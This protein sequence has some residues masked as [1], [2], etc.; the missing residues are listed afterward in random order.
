[1]NLEKEIL[2]Y[3][4]SDIRRVLIN[5]EKLKDIEEI[6]IFSERHII[7]YTGNGVYYVNKYSEFTK[8]AKNLFIPTYDSLE[9]TISL[10]CNNSIYSEIDSIKNGYLTL[11]C[12]HRVG[13]VGVAVMKNNEISYIKSVSCINIRVTKQIKGFADIIIN[14][15]YYDNHINNTL[16]ISPPQC[17]KT[18]LLRNISYLFGSEEYAKKV[19][20]VDERNEIASLVNGKVLNDIGLHSFVICEDL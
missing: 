11:P 4:S 14:D 1:M 13:I 19:G 7:L 17:G 2:R 20:I 15:I 18:T 16:V 9:K 10:M 5:I 12:G 6:R 8:N 3:L